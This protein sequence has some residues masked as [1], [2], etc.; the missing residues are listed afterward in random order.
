MS[1]N[2]STIPVNDM[3]LPKSGCP[4]C[5]GRKML[6]SR[7]VEYILGGAMMQPEIRI[8]TNEL[9]FCRPH[10]TA[11]LN[12]GGR[13]QVALLLQSHLKYVSEEVVAK[14]DKKIDKKTAPKIKKTAVS[15]YLCARVEASVRHLMKSTVNMWSKDDGFRQLFSQQEYICLP[16]CEML[17]YEAADKRL[18][19]AQLKLFYSQVTDLL[20]NRINECRDGID[21]FCKLFDYRSSPDKTEVPENCINNCVD[22]L[23]GDI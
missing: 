4:F 15:C 13:L 16:H 12:T 19:S 18:N 21:K 6:E 7:S 8:K 11:M 10:F 1:D 2:I 17:L 22:L 3:F 9:G 20:K 23:C 5:R 14:G